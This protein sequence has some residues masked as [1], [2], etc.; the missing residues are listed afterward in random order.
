MFK[1]TYPVG[2]SMTILVRAHADLALQGWD[3]MEVYPI[4]VGRQSPVVQTEGE[5]LRVTF[6]DDGELLVPSGAS[7]QVERV[8]GDAH[9]RNLTGKLAVE[10]VGGDLS[11]QNV[12]EAAFSYIGGDCEV[13]SVSGALAIHRVGGDLSAA[14]LQ[15]AAA[16]SNVG[17][18]A[19]LE[20][21]DGDLDVKAS[22]D[23]C[24]T[25]AQTVEQTVSARA[26]GDLDLY[27]LQ[28]ASALV[29]IIS[30][31]E[32]IRLRVEGVKQRLEQQA[33]QAT[34][35]EGIAKLS[36]QAGGDV[37][38][39]DEPHEE[40]SLPSIAANLEEYW[41]DLEES[42][43]EREEESDDEGFMSGEDISR[44]VNRHV[45]E[46]MRR[47]D[48]RIAAA[49]KRVEDRTRHMGRDGMVPP[50]PPVGR[51]RKSILTPEPP[52][53]PKPAAPPMPPAAPT[54]P[55]GKPAKMVVSEEERMLILTMLQEKKITAEEAAKLLEAL[56]RS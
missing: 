44:R 32:D 7:V 31:G 37:F 21:V 53:P 43:E 48:E 11:V 56:E 54:P 35:G 45:E 17:G 12:A 22:G 23:I 26:G 52:M 18:D 25:M 49:M 47:A 29:S 1:K 6:A 46:A 8:S 39:S 3:K 38:I 30:R 51:P 5:I 19:N 10:R 42:R 27:L 14:G 34:F 2:E 55:G 41:Q 28:G 24:L 40:E 36:L 50:I 20:L 9:I 15:G 16:V 13:L 33:H 4:D